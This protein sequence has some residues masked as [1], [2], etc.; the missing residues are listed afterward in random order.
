MGQF[1][2]DYEDVLQ[3][4]EFALVSV[5]RDDAEMTDW[6]AVDAVNGLIRT[7]TAEM[8]KRSAPTLS[9]GELSQHAFDRVKQMCE[10]R[11]GRTSLMTD[12]GTPIPFDGRI[13]N[14]EEIVQCL[15]RVRRSIELWNKELGRRGYF[16]FVGRFVD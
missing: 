13:L 3:N 2:E 12:D 9:L 5:Y 4:I 1:E 16:D 6:Q 15:K 8:R 10:L 14:V 11:L 7:Y